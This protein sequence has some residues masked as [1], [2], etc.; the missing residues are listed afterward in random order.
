MTRLSQNAG[1][2]LLMQGRVETAGRERE[3]KLHTYSDTDSAHFTYPI[4]AGREDR[5]KANFKMVQ[6]CGGC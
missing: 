3:A 5:Q 4:L 1:A 6:D 2:R